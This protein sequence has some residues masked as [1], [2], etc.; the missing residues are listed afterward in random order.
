MTIITGSSGF[1]MV[2]TGSGVSDT[3]D[4]TGSVTDSHGCFRR[5]GGG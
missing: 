5:V 2:Y 1:P 4:C 3:S